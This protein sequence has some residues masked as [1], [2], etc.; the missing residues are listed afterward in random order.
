MH[1]RMLRFPLILSSVALLSV[2]CS[3]D[4][5]GSAGGAT[6]TTQVGPVAAQPSAA[7][8]AASAGAVASGEEKVTTASGGAERWYY[9]YV[10]NGYSPTTPVPVVFDFHGYLEGADVH[11]QHS[12]LGPFG[13]EKGF[14]TITP[15]GLGNPVRWDTGL[16]SADIRFVGELLDEV[17]NTVCVDE[18]RI[19]ATGLSNGAFMTSAIACAYADRVAAVAP[20]AGISN[21]EGCKPARAVPVVAFH[22]TADSFIAFEGGLGESAR[23]LP[24]PDG[25]DRTL[26]ESGV[27]DR[28][29]GPS[30]PEVTA[31][32]AKRNGCTSEPTESKIADDVTLIEFSC[33]RGAEAELYRITD[34]GHTWPGSEFSKAIESAVGHT[35]FSI[36]ANEVMWEFFVDH[37]RRND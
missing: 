17:E 6:T 8:K 32:W 15:H 11:K 5:G 1:R 18:N 37:P 33:P 34:G 16:D 4:G 12:A 14:A 25:S 2:A 23:D 35:T 21:A 10:P 24:S 9:R 30:I 31:A 27:A 19:F 20:V 3:D 13:D 36:D 26:G 7:C 29:K 28:I 22:G